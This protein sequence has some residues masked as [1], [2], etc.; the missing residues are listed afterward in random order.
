MKCRDKSGESFLSPT[1]PLEA[2]RTVLSLA[3]TIVGSRRPCLDPKSS[4]RMQVSNIDIVRAY[5]DARIEENTPT[6]VE[7]PP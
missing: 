4:K 3:A 7:L 5:F 6:Y 1:P 2:L